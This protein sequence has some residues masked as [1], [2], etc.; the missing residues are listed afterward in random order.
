M[1]PTVLAHKNG[2]LHLIV[3]ALDADG[4]LMYQLVHGDMPVSLVSE[5]QLLRAGFQEAWQFEGKEGAGVP[6][7]VGT[8]TLELDRLWHNFGEVS[9]DDKLE[10]TFHLRNTGNK[11]VVVDKPFTSCSCTVPSLV[12]KTE[13]ASGETLDLKITT[14]V[15][16]SPSVRESIRLTFYEKGTGVSREVDLN[17]LGSRRELVQITPSRVDFGM[18]VPGKSYSR[19]LRLV[20]L[21]TDRFVLEG[22]DAGSL[23][24]TCEIEE[25][26]NANGLRAYRLHLNLS[27][28]QSET[29]GEH[30]SELLLAL[31]GHA[32][33][34]VKIPVRFEVESSVKAIPSAVALGTVKVGES[35]EGRVQLVSRNDVDLTILDCEA[36]EG[37]SVEVD[38]GASPPELIVKVQLAE[39]GIWRGVIRSRVLSSSGDEQS[40][41]IKCAAYGREAP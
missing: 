37:C 41:E 28:E 18:V 13:L 31:D 26:D 3:G 23:P 20:E 17:I 33:E 32:R 4:H 2:H 27:V 14:D 12:E 19:T 38:R 15:P 36:P 10:C 9:T 24:M 16:G 35:C 1:P 39:S 6:V 30:V 7:H 11:T 40:I 25:V 8:A 29:A 22:V 34:Q 5:A 21:P